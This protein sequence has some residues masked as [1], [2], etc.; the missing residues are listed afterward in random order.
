M[1]PSFVLLLL[2]FGLVGA[3]NAARILFGD[4]REVLR[5]A[6]LRT[7]RMQGSRLP[8]SAVT[9]DHVSNPLVLW[10]DELPFHPLRKARMRVDFHLYDE[11]PH[12][13]GLL[14]VSWH[15]A[16]KV[17]PVG[18]KVGFR[19]IPLPDAALRGLLGPAHASPSV[20]LVAAGALLASD[21]SI[22][23]S[24]GF[25]IMIVFFVVAS[26]FLG[27]VFAPIATDAAI[28]R[29]SRGARRT[30]QRL[31]WSGMGPGLVSHQLKLIVLD[32][33]QQPIAGILVHRR[34]LLG[35]F[36][37]IMLAPVHRDA[38]GPLMARLQGTKPAPRG[39]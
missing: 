22:P 33:S 4:R 1:T 15:A 23:A 29:W 9:I 31:L 28:R 8:P 26:L 37:S 12:R 16:S 35:L 10:D 36:T 38:V 20:P 24:Y 2:L 25:T 13:A 21:P 6:L 5:R 39:R 7:L 11:G 17:L 18:R 30:E 32:A 14:A 34:H 27:W 19:T 3:V